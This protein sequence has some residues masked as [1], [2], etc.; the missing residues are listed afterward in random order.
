MSLKY[1]E[2][3]KRFFLLLQM[4]PHTMRLCLKLAPFAVI[5][6]VENCTN[7]NFV[8][9]YPISNVMDRFSISFIL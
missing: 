2:L 7:Y 4:K 3:V 8:P 5:E 6:I 1:K 9:S